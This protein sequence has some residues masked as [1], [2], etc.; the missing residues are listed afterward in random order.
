[1]YPLPFLLFQQFVAFGAAG[2]A[3][4]HYGDAAQGEELLIGLADH[5]GVFYV[6]SL[7]TQVEWGDV[8]EVSLDRGEGTSLMFSSKQ[9]C[10]QS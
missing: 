3:I 5:D 10:P 2:S 8:L 4:S 6:L 7:R 1:L 9:C